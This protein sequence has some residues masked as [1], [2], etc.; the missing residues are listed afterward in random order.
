MVSLDAMDMAEGLQ[1]LSAYVRT[2]TTRDVETQTTLSLPVQSE[3]MTNIC[4]LS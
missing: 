4:E 1:I 2:R 3:S